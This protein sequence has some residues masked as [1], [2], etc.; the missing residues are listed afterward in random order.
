M[1]LGRTAGG[2]GGV[3]QAL[4]F[5]GR[6]ARGQ[7]VLLH[8]DGSDLCAQAQS[9]SP[10]DMPPAPL[11][12][13]LRSVVWPERTRHG[14]RVVQ[15]RGGGSL[16]VS[17]ATAFD[18]WRL[19]H[20]ARES[21]VVRAQQNWRAAL[22]AVLGMAVLV[23][24]GYHWG[25]PALAQ[26][27]VALIPPEVDRSVG[28]ATLAQIDSRWLSPS[29]LPAPRQAELKSLFA[30][31]VKA[32]FPTGQTLPA[33]DYELHFRAADKRIGPNAFALPGGGIIITDAL[34]ELLQGH[35]DTLLGVMAH[36][37]GHVQHRH[38][39]RGVVQLALVGA[40]TAVALGDFS[41]L[42]AGVPALLAQLAYSRDAERQSDAMAVQ[43][44]RAAGK[45]PAVMVL[46]FEQLPKARGDAVAPPIALASHPMDEERM[47]FFRDAAQ[48]R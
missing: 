17:D 14:Q 45:S 2:E 28:Q 9:A 22:I 26:G 27:V 1:N 37:L 8:V 12:W 48:G 39:M 35:D 41:T 47:H 43:V 46:L 32:A 38:G 29:T 24:A 42:L 31:A 21:W 13:P 11:R 3:I 30:Q 18:A 7:P 10:Q 23:V 4:Y 6:S 34:V 16:Q 33:P 20:G 36:E 44:L 15:L 25:V 40:V 19:A 5:D